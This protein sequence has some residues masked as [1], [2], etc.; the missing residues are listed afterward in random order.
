VHD[1][2][3]WRDF[4]WE[5]KDTGTVMHLWDKSGQ[6]TMAQLGRSE[7]AGKGPAVPAERGCSECHASIKNALATD[8]EFQS[9]LLLTLIGLHGPY[10]KDK[11][12]PAP[13]P[14]PLPV[15]IVQG[16]TGPQGPVGP[17]GIPGKDADHQVIIRAVKEWLDAHKDELRGKDGSAGAEGKTGPAGVAGMNGP[18]GAKGDPADPTK[19]QVVFNDSNGRER[20]RY[21]FSIDGVLTL[22]PLQ[23]ATLDDKDKVFDSVWFTWGVPLQLRIRDVKP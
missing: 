19:L 15:P 6:V 14:K 9:Q 11:P 3:G 5:D 17:Q 10:K 2:K 12:A 16:T 23:A 21:V 13:A 1:T 20:S 8:P 18:V 4:A 22:P 7:W